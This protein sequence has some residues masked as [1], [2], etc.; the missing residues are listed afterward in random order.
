LGIRLYQLAKELGVQSKDLMDKL[1]ARGIELKGHM[2][3]LEDRVADGL[4]A[5]YVRLAAKPAAP[6]AP[7]RPVHRPPAPPPGHAPAHPPRPVPP[8]AHPLRPAAPAKPPASPAPPPRP[9]APPP[10]AEAPKPAPPK[11]PGAPPRPAAPPAAQPPKPAPPVA[12]KPP[13]PPA[14]PPPPPPG[15]K[16]ARP[17]KRKPGAPGAVEPGTEEEAPK[18]VK[19]ARGRGR[20]GRHETGAE[21]VRHIELPAFDTVTRAFGPHVRVKERRGPEAAGEGVGLARARRARRP[22]HHEVR[23]AAPRIIAPAPT[24]VV[25]DFPVTLRSLSQSS[26]IKVDTLQRAL[27][28]NSIMANLNDALGEDVIQ[29]LAQEVGVEIQIRRERD[30]ETELAAAEAKPADPAALKPRAPVVAFLGHVD[31]GKTSLLDAIRQTRVV[32]TES[33]GITQ[34]IGAYSVEQAGRRV[35]FL[36]TPGHQA[37]T[38]MRSRGAHVTDIVVLVV[39]A[40]DGAMPQTEEAINHARAAKVPIVVAVNKVD[41]PAANPTRVM[42]QLTNLGLL[43]AKWG[44]DTECVEVSAL[45]KQGLP[46][47]ID[48]LA[49]QAEVLELKANPDRPA[50]GVVLEAHISEG[51]GAVATI[52]VRD[53]TLHVGDFV[54]CG[55]TYG[56]VR[57]L[58]DDRGQ[59]LTSAGPSMPVEI[60]GL[61]TVPGAGDLVVALDGLEQAREIAETRA[62]RAR[63]AAIAERAHVTLENLFATLEEGKPKEFRV[64]LK[65]DVQ[66]SLEVLRK[67]LNDL[68]TSEVRV[69]ML[70]A[71][72]GGINDSDILLADASDAVVLGFHVVAEPSARALAEQKKIDIRPYNVIYHLTDDVKA[73]LES[74]LEPERRENVVGHAQVRQVFRVSRAGSIAGGYVTDGRVARSDSVRLVRNNIIIYEGKLASLRRFKDDVR[75]VQNGMECGIKIAGYDDIKEGDVIQAYE[76]VEIKRKL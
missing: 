36:D 50:R 6:P 25:V 69:N 43:P 72:V 65:A 58:L 54:L 40:D 28:K 8:P 39:A 64:I 5:E 68:A 26:G 16:G 67:A 30:L 34:H 44:G 32:D 27:V 49:I 63:Q 13:G 46:D 59:P 24:K 73:A 41:L 70:H 47:L 35:V 62:S 15:E 45:T 2:S 11:L 66:G 3:T 74:R 1:R 18:E 20:G 29:K 31:H 48:T 9:A 17:K 12:P 71:A 23:E 53:G 10:T 22:M 33:G 51:R 76:V 21:I 14:P 38:A 75:E 56:R 37:F 55:M 57:S 52:L 61:S 60:S 19:R 4:R 7:P 42:Q